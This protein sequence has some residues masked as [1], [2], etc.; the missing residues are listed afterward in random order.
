VN[1]RGPGSG[2]ATRRKDGG[3]GVQGR[4]WRSGGG[5]GQAAWPSMRHGRVEYAD[6]WAPQPQ[7]R[8]LNRFKPS[9]SIQTRSNLFQI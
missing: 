7:C 3:G 6:M 1:G 5:R 4:Q 8:V 2:A 9:Q